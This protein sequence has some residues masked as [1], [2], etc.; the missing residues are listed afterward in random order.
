[1]GAGTGRVL[2]GMGAG[3]AL[4]AVA[5]QLGVAAPIVTWAA[6]PIGQIWL[7]LLLALLLPLA[8]SAL[9]LGMLGL[10]PKALAHAG[11][12]IVAL[13]LL[14]TGTAVLIGLAAA[15]IV[16]P[17]AGVDIS[18]LPG[19]T[20]KPT[21][22]SPI[23]LFVAQVPKNVVAAASGDNLL[24]VLVFCVLFGVALR[25]T[26]SEAAERVRELVQGLFDVSVR[27]VD[28]WMA[29][30][31]VGVGALMFRLTGNGGLASL[32]PLAWFVATVLGALGVQM[33]VV[34]PM[35]LRVFAR[36]DP[37]EFFR[38]VRPAMLVAFS[39]ASSAATLPASI[40]AAEN[41]LKLPSETARFVLT[42]GA[43]GNQ[44]GTALFEGLAVLFLAQLYGV[45]LGP[46]EQV[47]VIGVA[48]LG[49]IGTAGV[50]GGALGVI[51]AV[52]VTVGVPAE[53]IG[54]LLGV[55]RL[56]DMCRTTL[57]VTGDL[58]IAACTHVE[59]E[60]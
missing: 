51:A 18:A 34:Y 29:L 30:A 46:A 55:D 15:M 39:T 3:A 33:L 31:P 47:A 27:A 6:A 13:T 9:I 32:V 2:V 24:P 26:Q 59:P 17:G 4:G 35:V 20:V 42:V 52:C 23:D 14:L 8:S 41:G 44:N 36:R 43:T 10:D 50:P 58:V 37:L 19:G 5:W 22:G 38:A 45:D 53:A 21:T 7:N 57:N 49:G 25:S 12:R 54:V 40:D 1:M 11:G 16:Q 56:L 48:V 28:L 60:G